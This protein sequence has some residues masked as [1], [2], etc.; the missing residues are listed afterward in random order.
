MKA[1]VSKMK[2]MALEVA[3]LAVELGLADSNF[4]KNLKVEATRGRVSRGGKRLRCPWVGIAM[5]GVGWDYKPSGDRDLYNVLRWRAKAAS[6]KRT[7]NLRRL[8]ALCD[9][10]AVW[11]EYRS[12]AKD[13]EIGD[14]FGDRDDELLPLALILTHEVA[15]AVDYA[16]TPERKTVGGHKRDW[17][18]I[19][20]ALRTAY[21]ASGKYKALATTSNVI[22][23]RPKGTVPDMRLQ[24]L[25][26]FDVAA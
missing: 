21:V 1:T 8:D 7:R 10:K 19:Y 9:G 6:V 20:R 24:G 12:I 16:G 15:H 25:P 4:R 23:I 14:Y 13:P 26:L 3:D 11:C 18:E 17:Q 22:P 5:P 2:S